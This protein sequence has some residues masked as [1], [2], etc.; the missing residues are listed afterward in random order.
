STAISVPSPISYAA[1]VSYTLKLSI[2]N[3]DDLQSNEDSETFTPTFT[4]PATPTIDVAA[5]STQGY[6]QIA[7]ANSDSPEKGNELWRYVTSEGAA[8]AIRIAGGDNAIAVDGTFRDYNVRSGVDYTYFARAININ[9]LIADSVTDH[10]SLV[11]DKLWLSVAT[12][13][14]STSNSS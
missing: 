7:I 2:W 13:I 11:L 14:S 10:D 3:A 12:Q 8:S 5:Q 1:G 6:I 9:N 4:P